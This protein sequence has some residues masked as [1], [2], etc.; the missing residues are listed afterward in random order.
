MNYTK[1]LGG[2]TYDEQ[3]RIL[4]AKLVLSSWLTDIDF[5]KVNMDKAGNDFGTA[6]W[7]WCT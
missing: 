2:I 3:G 4:S 7:V 5:T 1:L 6:D